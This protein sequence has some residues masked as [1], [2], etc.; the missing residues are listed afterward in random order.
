MNAREKLKIK[1]INSCVVVDSSR[2]PTISLEKTDLSI[3]RLQIASLVFMGY[4]IKRSADKQ[5]C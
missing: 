4:V 2:E 5:T 1:F 3:E